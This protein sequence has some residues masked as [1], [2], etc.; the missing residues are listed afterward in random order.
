MAAGSPDLLA[1]SSSFASFL[2][3]S[4]LGR[5]GRGRAACGLGN[6][7]ISFHACLESAQVRLKEGSYLQLC[8]DGWALPFPRTGCAPRAEKHCSAFDIRKQ[9]KSSGRVVGKQETDNA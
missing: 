5:G 6:I 2:Y 9:W 3:C 8:F 7:R 1:R 4:A